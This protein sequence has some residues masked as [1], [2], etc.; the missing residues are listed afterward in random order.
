MK[1]ITLKGGLQMPIIGFGTW[2]LE[3]E[4]CYQAVTEALKIGYRHIDTAKVYDN[5]SAVGKAINESG[6]PRS[7]IFLTT[8]L[9][10]DFLKKEYIK[11]ECKASLDKLNQTY[12]D[13]YLIHWP[14]KE[15]PIKETLEGLDELKQEG[16]IKSFGVSNFT[17]HHLQDVLKTGFDIVNNQVEFHPTLYQKDLID[18]CQTN[19]IAVTAYSPIGQGRDIKLAPILNLAEKYQRSPAQVVISWI[20]SKNVIAIPRS[21]NPQ[22]IADNIRASEWQL[23]PEDIAVIDKL[24]EDYR[25]CFPDFNEFNY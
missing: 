13:L 22:N 12:V 14:N 20:N 6:I 21:S 4:T 3:P 19:D 10:K 7:E 18:F 25:V 1:M 17:I 9:W 15:V 5:E 16:L 24:N 2:Q 23:E 11:S 8:K